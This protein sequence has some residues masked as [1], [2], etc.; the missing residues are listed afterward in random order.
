[1][2]DHVTFN[3]TIDLTWS[4]VKRIRDKVAS[5]VESQ[6]EELAYACK[7]TSSELVENAVKYG[8]S[9]D[10]KKGIAFSFSIKDNEVR[11]TVANGI[12][13]KGDFESV[14]F[15]ISAIN[16]STNPQELYINRL[17]TLLEKPELNQSQLGLYRIAYEGEFRLEYDYDDESNVLT[18]TAT[19]KI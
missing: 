6:G 3:Y 14:K 2:G 5:L 19:K 11:I 13:N 8:C 7:M 18:V 1:M 4:I 12:I 15:H 10:D 17:N 9:I 16:A